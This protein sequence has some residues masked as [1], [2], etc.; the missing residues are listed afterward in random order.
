MKDIRKEVNFLYTQSSLSVFEACPYKFKLRYFQGLY[1]SEDEATRESFARGNEFHLLAERYYRR[2]SQE[3]SEGTEESLVEDLSRLKETYPLKD[4]WK[5]FPEFDI[6]YNKEGVRLLGRYD[7]ILVKPQNKIQIIDFKTNKKKLDEK[8]MEEALQTRIYLFLLWENYNL[9]LE[10]AR[11][12]RSLEM[13]YY[14]TE[15]PKEQIIIKYDEKKHDENRKKIKKIM[16]EIESFSFAKVEKTRVNHCNVCEFR[17][18]CW[19]D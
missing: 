14:Q 13:I 10:N 5:Y 6:R 17:K 11:K 2:I 7:L 1:W 18:I 9:I 8:I 16:K 15:Y 4:G 19:K 12:I 3:K